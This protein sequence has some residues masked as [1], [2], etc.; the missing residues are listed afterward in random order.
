MENSLLYDLLERKL[1][2]YYDK[3]VTADKTELEE[4]K[5]ARAKLEKALTKE[6]LELSDAYKHLCVL[7]DEY[8]EFQV[9][10]RLL[11]YGVRIGMQL[12]KSFVDYDGE[13]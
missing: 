10:I 8:I 4:I 5:D 7:R 12:Q 2:A 13:Q 9:K 3:L 11:N 6:Q 1:N